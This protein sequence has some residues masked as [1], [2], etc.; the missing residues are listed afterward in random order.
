VAS[1]AIRHEHYDREP[2]APWTLRATRG[3]A[4]SDSQRKIEAL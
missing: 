2:I 3:V 1:E 4:P